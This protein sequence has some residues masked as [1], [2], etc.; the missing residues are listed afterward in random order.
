MSHKPLIKQCEESHL[1][2]VESIRKDL[3]L[4]WTM[5]SK[6]SVGG[7]AVSIMIFSIKF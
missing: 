7:S 6:A 1:E 4:I 2:D 3:E 5:S